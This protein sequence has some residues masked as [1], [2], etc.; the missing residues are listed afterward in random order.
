MGPTISL[1]WREFSDCSA[2]KG[3]S[4]RAQRSLQVNEIVR[5]MNMPSQRECA[6]QRTGEERQAYR[7]IKRFSVGPFW[8]FT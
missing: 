1:D 7:K 2:E 5:D 3:N 8:I 4:V 6:L